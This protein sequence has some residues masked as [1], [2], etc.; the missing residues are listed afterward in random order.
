M[1]DSKPEILW[2]PDEFDPDDLPRLLQRLGRA[3]EAEPDQFL[4]PLRPG[5]TEDEILTRLEPC[6]IAPHP[7]LVHWFKWTAGPAPDHP[8]LH[9]QLI[10]TTSEQSLLPIEHVVNQMVTNDVDYP[11][12]DG[13]PDYK[14]GAWIPIFNKAVIESETGHIYH[15]HWQPDTILFADRLSII[16]WYWIA[17][18]EERILPAARVL[19][20]RPGLSEPVPTIDVDYEARDEVADLFPGLS[21]PRYPTVSASLAGYF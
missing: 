6:G 7:D 1:T 5:L 15:L 11:V 17:L 16:I 2:K 20:K 10:N 8:E 9:Y 21:M 18:R 19:R 13:Y 3:L 4:T 14:P 12:D